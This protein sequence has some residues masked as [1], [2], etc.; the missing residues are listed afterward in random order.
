MDLLCVG[1]CMAGGGGLSS[2]RGVGGDALTGILVRMTS[3]V[4]LA[5]TTEAPDR[6]GLLSGET[7]RLSE[8]NKNDIKMLYECLTLVEGKTGKP[9][10]G[11]TIEKKKIEKNIYIFE[12]PTIDLCKSSIKKTGEICGIHHCQC[13]MS[14]T[15]HDRESVPQTNFTLHLPL[16]IP[17][18]G[19]I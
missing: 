2:P 3:F 19:Y 8:K 9:V 10:N 11:S 16:T 5:G 1:G 17:Y 4:L 6:T 13:P 18:L 15:C 12:G 14:N 7:G